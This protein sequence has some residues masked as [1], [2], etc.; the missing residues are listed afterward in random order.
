VIASNGRAL[1]GAGPATAVVRQF[2]AD[3]VLQY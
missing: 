3:V 1:E 2:P